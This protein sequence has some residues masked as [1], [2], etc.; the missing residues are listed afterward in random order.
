MPTSKIK[1]VRII[2]PRKIDKFACGLARASSG[3]ASAAV[4]LARTRQDR[5]RIKE[6]E[7][8]LLLWPRQQPCW[9]CQKKL[10]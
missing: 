3:S 10:R 9:Y 7:R 2:S 6:L 5:K 1:I 4:A 8:E